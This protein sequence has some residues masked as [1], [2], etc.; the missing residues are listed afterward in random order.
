MFQRSALEP[1]Y[2][3]DGSV[4]YGILTYGVVAAS[5]RASSCIIFLV[6]KELIY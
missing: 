6:M 2:H 5:L 4:E 1:A 3:Q